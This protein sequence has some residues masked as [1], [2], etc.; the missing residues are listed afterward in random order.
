VSESPCCTRQCTKTTR[1]PQATCHKLPSSWPTQPRPWQ[2]LQGL[3]AWPKRA[4]ERSQQGI[5]LACS[6]S[7]ERCAMV[8]PRR[9]RCWGRESPHYS[10][11][12]QPQLVCD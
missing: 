6:T 10:V 3:R 7:L 9:R 4:S 11:R 2:T 8:G 1:R 12:Q 5:V